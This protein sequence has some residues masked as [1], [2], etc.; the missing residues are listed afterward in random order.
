VGTSR[1]SVK[2][3]HARSR[4]IREGRMWRRKPSSGTDRRRLAAAALPS[5]AMRPVD[6]I[7]TAPLDAAQLGFRSVARR[8]R[9]ERH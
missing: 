3:T 7:R 1:G 4:G 5:V 6:A 8:V 9:A 2:R